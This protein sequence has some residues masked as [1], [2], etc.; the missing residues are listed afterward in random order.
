MRLLGPPVRLS[1]APP[2]TLPADGHG[3]VATAAVSFAR[4]AAPR[5]AD[6]PGLIADEARALRRL[7]PGRWP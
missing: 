3:T 6:L 1:A 5:P 2:D 4:A 7:L